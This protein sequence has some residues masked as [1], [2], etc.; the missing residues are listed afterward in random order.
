[1]RRA[2]LHCGRRALAT[3]ACGCGAASAYFYRPPIAHCEEQ[4]KRPPP[5]KLSKL[6]SYETG[7]EG[8]LAEIF[9]PTAADCALAGLGLFAGIATLELLE[10]LV[11]LQ[12]FH[13]AMMASGIIFFAGPSP[14][15]PKGFL[16]GTLCSATLSFGVLTVLSPFVPSAIAQGAAAGT[17]LVWYMANNCI[18]PPAAVLAGALTTVYIS[19][20]AT[21]SSTTAIM[22]YL[23]FP[24]LAG[25]AFLYATAHALSYVRSEARVRLTVR[26]LHSLHDLKD[27]ALYDIF[28]KFDTDA[29]GALDAD[30]LKVA[31]RVALGVDLSTRDC[32][33]LIAVADKDGTQTIDFDEF[34]FI[35]KEQI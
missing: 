16:A 26:Q 10:P 29:S 34:K 24:W 1:M 18:F 15:H 9:S 13:P 23:A 6:Q 4:P 12:L 28:L 7:Q 17:L 11:G 19:A 14:P 8:I 32:E 3:A 31:L 35:V 33:A 2:Y 27:D 30:E 5:R 21:A 25:H 20:A 22:R